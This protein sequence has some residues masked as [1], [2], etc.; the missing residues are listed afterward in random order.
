MLCTIIAGAKRHRLEP[1][2]YLQDV[3][4]QLSVDPSPEMSGLAFAGALGFGASPASSRPIA[5]TSH[6]RRHNGVTNAERSEGLGRSKAEDSGAPARLRPAF[7]G[8]EAG[9]TLRVGHW[10]SPTLTVAPPRPRAS[11]VRA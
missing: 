7:S 8:R 10:E 2:A 11:R 5:W 3:I 4:L 6:V 9:L 1:W